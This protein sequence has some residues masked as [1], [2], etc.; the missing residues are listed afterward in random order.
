MTHNMSA[1][2]T[3][4]TAHEAIDKFISLNRFNRTHRKKNKRAF[5]EF[6]SHLI[7]FAAYAPYVHHLNSLGY[8]C[9]F[10]ILDNPISRLK[11]LKLKLQALFVID[12]I[13]ARPFY[14]FRSMKF[15]RFL[16]V[17]E[18]KR[19]SLEVSSFAAQYMGL[20]KTAI[21]EMS[22]EEIHVGD[23]FY[24]WHL[25][26]RGLATI[27][28]SSNIFY[29]DLTEFIQ[30]AMNW[31]RYLQK[32]KF[33][34]VIITHAVY[35][36]GLILRLSLMNGS[37]VFLVT[38]EKMFHLNLEMPLSDLESRKYRTDQEIE[39]SY[40]VD[41]QSAKL[42][43]EKLMSGSR[44]VDIAHSHVN[45][46]SGSETNKVIH[47]GTSVNV[48]IATHCFSDSP[49]TNGSHLFPDFM[50][51]LEWLAR[52]SETT[53]YDWYIKAHPAFFP[54]DVVILDEFCSRNPHI[55]FLSSAY[56][57]RELV[58]QGINVVLTVY[59]TIAFEMAYLGALVVNASEFAPHSNYNFSLSPRSITDYKKTL[60][61]LELL[62]KSFPIDR[63]EIIHFYDLH[64]LRR[65]YYWLFETS[66]HEISNRFGVDYSRPLDIFLFYLNLMESQTYRDNI[67][68]KINN[69]INS[70]SY[71]FVS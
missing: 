17:F 41:I 66:F 1:I 33:E 71:T 13:E 42:K 14:V 3:T 16:I 31:K 56:S 11:T 29:E 18:R 60:D 58:S 24:D 46:M 45:G 54:S 62:V 21:L 5:F 52:Y 67:R 49:H 10:G 68:A 25:R 47:G 51:W 19:N 37:E 53:E 43:L 44:N 22:F 32:K 63:Q 15:A 6:Q 30:F 7:G 8:K 57:N 65:N 23:L 26:K 38:P 64:H 28:T 50:E 9:Y 27:D 4:M 35:L 70:N 61:N 34:F 2:A 59:G 40:H 55:K 69:F 36:Q 20:S 12:K 48:M 39:L